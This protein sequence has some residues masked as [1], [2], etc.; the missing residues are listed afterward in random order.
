[1]GVDVHALILSLFEEFFQVKQVMTG[2]KDSRAGFGPGRDRGRNR[3][4]EMFGMGL[5]QKFHDFD[6]YFSGFEYEF[7]ES[8]R[9][10]IDIG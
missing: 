1:M 7:E 3:I 2:D 4:T 8:A 5:I 9:V 10:E 6:I